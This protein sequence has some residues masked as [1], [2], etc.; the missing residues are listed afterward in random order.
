MEL[1]LVELHSP[2]DVFHVFKI[3]ETVPNH[4]TRLILFF[5]FALLREGY[6]IYPSEALGIKGVRY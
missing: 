4:A 1:L 6:L 2:I 3:V 5:I